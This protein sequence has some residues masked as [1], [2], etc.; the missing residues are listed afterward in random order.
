MLEKYR[1][2]KKERETEKMTE[3]DL[4]NQKKTKAMELIFYEKMYFYV[5]TG[6]QCKVLFQESD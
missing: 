4:A 6:F 5:L 2:I 3:I 1:D